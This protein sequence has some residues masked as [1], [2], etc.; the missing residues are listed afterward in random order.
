[1]DEKAIKKQVL[2]QASAQPQDFF[3]VHT[4]KAKGFVRGK[5]S[6]RTCGRYFWSLD[7]DQKTC[8]DPACSGG[9]RFIGKKVTAKQLQYPE[10]W[11]AFSEVHEKLG[12]TPIKRYP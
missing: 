2:A 4:L 7:A 6:N 1:M 9:F 5:C 8:G 11:K 12:Y 3:P 10:V